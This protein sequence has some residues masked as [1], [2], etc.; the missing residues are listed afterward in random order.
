M[1]MNRINNWG[2]YQELLRLRLNSKEAMA[3]KLLMD[4][5]EVRL[6]LMAEA[7]KGEES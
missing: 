5:K 3:D 2:R 6:Q 7:K 4:G 1:V